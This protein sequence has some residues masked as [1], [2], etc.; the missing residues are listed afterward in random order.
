MVMMMAIGKHVVRKT[1]DSAHFQ[2][3]VEK[4][5]LYSAAKWLI[6]THFY[7]DKAFG[8]CTLTFENLYL[9][10]KGRNGQWEIR[11]R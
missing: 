3:R 6:A 2:R 8:Y 4:T 11:G 5:V 7:D 1:D 10:S 9:V